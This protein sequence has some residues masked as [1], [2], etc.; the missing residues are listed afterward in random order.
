MNGEISA[1]QLKRIEEMKRQVMNRI[2]TKDAFE[3]LGRVRSVDPQ[4]AGQAELYLLQIYQEGKIQD[5]VTD[6]KLKGVLKVL[7]EKRGF[8]IRRR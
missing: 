1:E 3:R 2:L 7:S 8:R 5:R 6:E 4:L